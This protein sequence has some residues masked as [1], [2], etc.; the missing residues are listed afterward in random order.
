MPPMGKVETAHFEEDYL[1][2]KHHMQCHK[3]LN[4]YV[5]CEERN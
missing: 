5:S 4:N 1:S 3:N 2:Y